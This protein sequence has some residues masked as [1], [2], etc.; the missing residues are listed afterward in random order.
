MSCRLLLGSS[1]CVLHRELSVVAL[2]A[3]DPPRHR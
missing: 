3:E 1:Y 2:L